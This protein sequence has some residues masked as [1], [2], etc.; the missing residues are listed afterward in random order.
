MKIEDATALV[1]G[2][3]R[4]IGEAFVRGLLKAGARR[5]YVGARNPDAAVHLVA[6][7]PDRVIALKLDVTKPD[8]IAEAAVACIDLS[9]LIN[10]AGAFHNQTL[11]GADD[12]TAARDWM[13][14]SAPLPSRRSSTAFGA[15]IVIR[16]GHRPQGLFCVRL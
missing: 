15:D 2:G 7:A 4:G 13:R 5:V 16:A 1:T 12:L 11:L 6:E 9:I 3:N 10:N 8:Q 14:C